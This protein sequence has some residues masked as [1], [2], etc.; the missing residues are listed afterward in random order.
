MKT[1]I[2]I[3]IFILLLTTIIACKPVV[4]DAI[5]EECLQ[6]EN[7]HMEVNDS[8]QIPKTGS[9]GGAPLY[10]LFGAKPN[11]EWSIN[12]ESEDYE[13]A[14]MI[15]ELMPLETFMAMSDKAQDVFIA[16]NGKYDLLETTDVLQNFLFQDVK[17]NILLKKKDL[18][19]ARVTIDIERTTTCNFVVVNYVFVL[20]NN[21]NE[22]KAKGGVKSA[23]AKNL[24]TKNND[25]SRR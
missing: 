22:W 11:G 23:F 17:R 2:A 7:A 5:S 6:A 1:T 4:L 19:E 18:I 16:E 20:K 15:A 3:R 13:L 21:G 25:K 10:Y 9:I 14:V 12:I 24:N 8:L